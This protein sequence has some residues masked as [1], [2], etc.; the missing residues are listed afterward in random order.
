MRPSADKGLEPFRTQDWNVP[1]RL[2][3]EPYAPSQY[4]PYY[5]PIARPSAGKKSRY[6]SLGLQLLAF[7]LSVAV[8]GLVA[9]AVAVYKSSKDWK[10][11]MGGGVILP[12]WHAPGEHF[13]TPMLSLLGSAA[14]AVALGVL[15]LAFMAYSVRHAPCPLPMSLGY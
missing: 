10:I 4:P 13:T 3:P 7:A 12:G 5:P 9:N 15:A 14:T 2:T 11:M 1:K 6:I 8:L